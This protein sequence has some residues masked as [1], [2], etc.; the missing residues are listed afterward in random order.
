MINTHAID[1]DAIRHTAQNCMA[2]LAVHWPNTWPT[3]ES[4]LQEVRD[5]H[6]PGSINQ[7]ALIND[8]RVLGWADAINT[9]KPCG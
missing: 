6:A 2:P 8:S 3:F 7:I 5:C 1:E 9:Y 4:A